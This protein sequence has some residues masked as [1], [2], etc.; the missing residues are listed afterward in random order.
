[1]GHLTADYIHVV[2]ESLKLAMADRDEYYGDPRFVDVPLRELL[3][4]DYTSLRRSLVDLRLASPDR[5]PGDP[6]GPRATRGP[7]HSADSTAKIPVQD[8][9]TCV[10][11]DRWGNVV[12]TTPSGNALAGGEVGDSGIQMSCRLLCSNIWE[13]HPNV[14]A[15]DK[16]PRTTLTP[17]LVLKDGKAIAAVDVA[18]GDLQ[19]Q[20]SLQLLINYID[21]GMNPVEC[22]T[23][24]RFYTGHYTG[25]FGQGRPRLGSLTVNRDLGPDVIEDLKSRGHNL[26]LTGGPSSHDCIL[27]LDP[28][29]GLI[30]A[31]GDPKTNRHAG[32][33]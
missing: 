14:V 18:G 25:S 24:P 20:A 21:F 32:A 31:T 12:A 26:R 4:D 2:I 17:T 11:A 22:V 10:V 19:D 3:S 5:R 16:R 9:T 8:T 23:R 29:T 27:T 1:M 6:Y 33:F 15:P 28:Q 30:R 7:D 13:G